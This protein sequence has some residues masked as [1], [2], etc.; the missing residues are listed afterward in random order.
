MK[1]KFAGLIAAVGLS[2]SALLLSSPALAGCFGCGCEPRGLIYAAPPCG[3]AADP[4][5]VVNQ[6]PTY[7]EPVPPAAWTWP[8]Y[9]PISYPYVDDDYGYWP[10]YG[11]DWR[12]YGYGWRGYAR[13]WRGYGRPYIRHHARAPHYG[14]RAYRYRAHR[15]GAWPAAR[16]YPRAHRHMH[17]TRMHM[18]QTQSRRPHVHRPR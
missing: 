6:G 14:F 15:Y 12:G 17:M 13:A 3:Y 5:Y 16:P 18:M 1:S 4:F 7:G 11:Y 10:G 9:A 2:A 8:R